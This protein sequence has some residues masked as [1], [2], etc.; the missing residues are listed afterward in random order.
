MS[1]AT[2]KHYQGWDKATTVFRWV[3]SSLPHNWELWHRPTHSACYNHTYL[4][5]LVAPRISRHPIWLHHC[6]LNGLGCR[7]PT[8]KCLINASARWLPPLFAGRSCF[9]QVQLVRSNLRSLG[10]LLAPFATHGEISIK[11]PLLRY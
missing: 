6:S 5:S 1:L 7:A 8:P 3:Q 9:S 2:V 11:P 10:A 4:P